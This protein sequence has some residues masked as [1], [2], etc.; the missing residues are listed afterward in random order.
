M[1]KRM[2]IYI[3]IYKKEDLSWFVK[4]NFV[5]LTGLYGGVKHLLAIKRL[6]HKVYEFFSENTFG[7]LL[8]GN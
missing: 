1:V 7:I 2:I 8:C 4:Y 5:S 6:D 3:T